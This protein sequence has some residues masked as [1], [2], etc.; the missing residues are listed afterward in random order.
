MKNNYPIAGS[1]CGYNSSISSTG[2]SK[3]YITEFVFN[4]FNIAFISAHL[5]A[6]P[7][8]PARC[9]QREAQASILQSVIYYYIN[10]NYEVIMIGDLNDYDAEVLDLNNNEPTSQVVDILKGNTGEYTGKYLLYSAAEK[11]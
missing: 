9:S 8:D 2:V 1:K 7:S 3:H 11:N 6:I 10:H 5:I 4:G